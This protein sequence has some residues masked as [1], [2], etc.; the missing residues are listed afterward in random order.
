MFC[1]RN[2]KEL[3]VE[4]LKEHDY[5]TCDQVVGDHMKTDNRVTKCV[6]QQNKMSREE[7]R[8]CNESEVNYLR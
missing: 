6:N 5:S 1:L 8:S 2:K 7:A 3:L 4:L